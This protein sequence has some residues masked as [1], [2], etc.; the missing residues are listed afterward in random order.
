MP[1][2]NRAWRRRQAQRAKHRTISFLKNNLNL[3]YQAYDPKAVGIW[4][5]THRRPCSCRSCG[6]PRKYYGALTLQEQRWLAPDLH[7]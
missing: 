3:K 2:R 5:S 4:T 6:N 1:Y 7:M